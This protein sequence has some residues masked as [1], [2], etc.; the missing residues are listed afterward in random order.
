MPSQMISRTS[1]WKISAPPP[2]SDPRPASRSLHEHLL[3]RQLLALREP[4]DLD[5]R[6]RL[7]VDVGEALLEAAEHLEVPLEGE[8]GVQAADDVE[9]G[10]L[11][12]A[13]LGG[14]RVDVLV[15]HLP[16][17]VL[18][19]QRREAAELAVVGVDA[20]VGRID[21]AVD[22]EVRHVAVLATA[23]GVGETAEVQDVRRREAGERVR[24]V[25]ALAVSYFLCQ[26]L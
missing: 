1:S 13:L 20:D 15:R 9:L 4:A 3:D 22:V 5:R 7:Q 12:A 11:V 16:G 14:V 25:E 8:F 17:V 26:L 24:L 10:H 18:A 2:G 19:R 6:E 23:H 21:V